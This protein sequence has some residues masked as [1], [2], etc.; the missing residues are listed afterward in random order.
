MSPIDEATSLVLGHGFDEQLL[1]LVDG[2]YEPLAR[3]DLGEGTCELCHWLRPRTDEYGLV[4]ERRQQ[5]RAEQRG[6]ATPG[7]PDDGE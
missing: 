3:R 7:R 6:L 5:A 2:E 4:A 1:E